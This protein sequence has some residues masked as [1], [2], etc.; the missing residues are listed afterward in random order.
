M[1]REKIVLFHFLQ[2][3]GKEKWG[4]E[5]NAFHQ[6]QLNFIPFETI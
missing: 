2:S 6:V 4:I 3:K 1:N 5:W